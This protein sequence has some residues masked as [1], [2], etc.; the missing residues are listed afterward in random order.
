MDRDDLKRTVNSLMLEDDSM[1]KPT[2]SKNMP[3][4]QGISVTRPKQEKE[5]QNQI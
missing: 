3:Q 1:Q 4:K 2:L 5:R